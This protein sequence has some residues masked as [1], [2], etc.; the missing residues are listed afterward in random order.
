MKKL[1][2]LLFSFALFISCSNDDDAN[3]EENILG[4][5]YIAEAN[6]I[7]N[8][9]LS[10]CNRESSITFNSDKTTNSEYYVGSSNPCTLADETNSVWERDGEIYTFSLP[11]EG[12]ENFDLDNINGNVS[13]NSDN[14]EFTF[15]PLIFPAASVIFEKR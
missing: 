8:F 11:I 1:F 10:T 7:P 12:L 6:G 5:W 9:E 3:G 15:T 2:L 4:T 14:S 13:F